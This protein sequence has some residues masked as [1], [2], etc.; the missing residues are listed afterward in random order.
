MGYYHRQLQSVV[1]NKPETTKRTKVVLTPCWDRRAVTLSASRSCLGLANMERWCDFD[2]RA[3]RIRWKFGWTELLV[4]YLQPTGR[5][6]FPS[7]RW[8]ML[9][10]LM[11]MCQD[12]DWVWRWSRGWLVVSSVFLTCFFV[13]GRKLIAFGELRILPRKQPGEGE[14]AGSSHWD[15]LWRCW[16]PMWHLGQSGCSLELLHVVSWAGWAQKEKT[17]GGPRIDGAKVSPSTYW[18]KPSHSLVGLCKFL[19]CGYR[20]F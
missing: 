11:F 5:M 18:S 15:G 10:D 12:I 13:S 2:P 20:F 4:S 14:A 7:L 1:P 8:R 16:K 19:L 6:G 17:R 3:F 9:N